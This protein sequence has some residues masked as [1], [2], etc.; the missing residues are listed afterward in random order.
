MKKREARGD[1]MDHVLDEPANPRLFD[2]MASCEYFSAYIEPL[3]LAGQAWVDPSNYAG[4]VSPAYAHAQ[5]IMA[6]QR[7]QE[8]SVVTL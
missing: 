4:K 3:F 7:A 8:V 1:T 2:C 6:K 5:K